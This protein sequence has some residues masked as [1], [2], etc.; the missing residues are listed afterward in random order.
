MR[1]DQD[2]PITDDEETEDSVLAGIVVMMT[3]VVAALL[4]AVAELGGWH[5]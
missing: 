4:C 1:D 3:F 2:N 5:G